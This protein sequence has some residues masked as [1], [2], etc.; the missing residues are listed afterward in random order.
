MEF[1][2]YIGELQDLKKKG[3][4]P[5][6]KDPFFKGTLQKGIGNG[7]NI[8]IR[9]NKQIRLEINGFIYSNETKL[10]ASLDKMGIQY[11]VV[12]KIEFDKGE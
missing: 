8:L 12:E 7:F 6:S 11:E 10:K 2:N 1:L 9:E 4:I 5:S 3:F